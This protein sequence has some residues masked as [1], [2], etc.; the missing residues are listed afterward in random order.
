MIGQLVSH[1][2]R[3]AIVDAAAAVADIAAGRGPGAK[4]DIVAGALVGGPTTVNS[5]IAPAAG[6]I[7]SAAAALGTGC[8]AGETVT[9]DVQI[10]GVSCLTAPYVINAASGTG[11]EQG[12]VD[13]AADDFVAGDLITVI[14]TQ[15]DAGGPTSADLFHSIGWRLT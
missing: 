14:W 9:I 2:V 15:A 6:T 11:V 7:L 5:F 12:A 13:P 10:G 8:A 3:D 1:D 4:S